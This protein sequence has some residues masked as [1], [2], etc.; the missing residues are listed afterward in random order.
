MR[1]YTAGLIDGEGT[2]SVNTN[3]IL[4]VYI[5]NSSRQ[6]LEYV[7]SHLGG[8]ITSCRREGRK[9]QHTLYWSGAG[10]RD[11]LDMLAEFVILKSF[12]VRMGILYYNSFFEGNTF[13]RLGSDEKEARQV[14]RDIIS[15]N[16]KGMP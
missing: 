7:Q 15:P 11:I 5:Y 8:A 1:A 14:F 13:H 12:K 6:L 2:I 16:N 9:T 3:W 4:R 10:A